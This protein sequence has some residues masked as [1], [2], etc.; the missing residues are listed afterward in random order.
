MKR[1]LTKVESKLCKQGI[2]TRKKKIA[3]LDQELKYFV[4]FN[5]FND[6]WA[7]Y[8]ETKEL[9]TKERKKLIITETL[10][11]LKEQITHE[12]IAMKIEQNQLTD[13]VEIK[14]MTG[15]Q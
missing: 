2:N 14:T 10:N 15:V 5:A 12:K 6:K 1:K 9:K 7:K 8:L 13:G 11:Q 3:E 4:E